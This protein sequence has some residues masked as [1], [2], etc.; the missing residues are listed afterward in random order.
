MLLPVRKLLVGGCAGAAL[1]DPL[2]T[3]PWLMPL[4][5]Y[6]PLERTRLP[7]LS[8]WFETPDCASAA[9]LWTKN[10]Y[11]YD[12]NT[13][14]RLL[15]RATL[16]V[17]FEATARLIEAL[18]GF[19]ASSDRSARVVICLTGVLVALTGVLVILTG[20]LIWRTATL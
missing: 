4:G 9:E 17:Q 3:G 13:T 12:R 6:V 8:R 5:E 19:K 11:D 10:G 2:L 14:A 1:T 20:V 7:Y 15:A 18:K 16:K